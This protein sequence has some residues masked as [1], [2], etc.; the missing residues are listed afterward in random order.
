[1][2]SPL[3][4]LASK[5]QVIAEF[6]AFS[7]GVST[8]PGFQGWLGNALVAGGTLAV[9]FQSSQSKDGGMR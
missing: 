1:M 6:M 7:F 5:K 2:N 4:V 3:T 9:V 8:L